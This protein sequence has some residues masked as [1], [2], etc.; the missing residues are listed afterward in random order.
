M[1]NSKQKLTSDLA[2]WWGNGPGRWMRGR[3]SLF[4]SIALLLGAGVGARVAWDHLEGK[5]AKSP[6]YQLN[7]Q[8]VQLSPNP[9][10]AWIRTDIKQEVF[11]STTLEQTASLLDAP[12]ELQQQIIDAFEL[13]PWIRSVRRIEFPSPSQV[14]V[15]V[16]YREP[17]AV[18]EVETNGSRELLPVDREGVRLPEG[19]L[20]EAEK[21]YLPRIADIAGRPQVG[22]A[23]TDQR[24]VGAV[25]LAVKL[26][27]VWDQYR[28]LEIVP[29]PHPEV[30]RAERYYTYGI[31]SSGGTFIHWGASPEFQPTGESPFEEKLAR[32]SQYIGDYG[33]LNS[34][35]TPEAIDVRNKLRIKKRTAKREN[36]DEVVR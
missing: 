18:A 8:V 10:P 29:S 15:E 7:A 21:S 17:V 4:L 6:R 30:D 25:A 23:W 12:Q 34:I 1:A 27:K 11:L 31:R 22:Q 24:V 26:R 14:V 3:P 20:T 28:L 35:H 2:I 5:L 16:E 33:P 36:G 32:L 19:G 13:H 9:P